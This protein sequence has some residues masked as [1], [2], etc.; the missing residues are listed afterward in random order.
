[1]NRSW[2]F[3]PD[4]HIRL[5]ACLTTVSCAEYCTAQLVCHVAL[6]ITKQMSDM[7]KPK[8]TAELYCMQVVE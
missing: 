1:M 3:W 5:P 7:L 2:R 8:S 4:A 6:H